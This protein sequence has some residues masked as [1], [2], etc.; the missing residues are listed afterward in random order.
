MFQPFDGYIPG[1]QATQDASR[2]T[3]T[4]G[5]DK[6]NAWIQGNHRINGTYYMAYD[7]DADVTAFGDL[8][9]SLGWWQQSSHPDWVLYKCDQR[10][11]AWVG[12]LPDNVPLD[13]SN[14][15]VVQYQMALVS[16]YM[17]ANGYNSFAADVMS[18][19]N[20]QG[21]CGV[22]TH[23]HTVWVKKFSGQQVDPKWAAATQYWAAYAQWYLH[24]LPLP[25]PFLANAPNWAPP[26]DQ[27]QKELISHLDGFQDEGGFTAFGNH[28]IND[29]GFR[30]KIWWAQYIQ[31]QGKA[32]LVTDLWKGAEPNPVQR[33]FA[34]A[35]YLMGKY[36]QAAMVTAQYG[37]Y[38]VEHYWPEYDSA[39]GSPC[40][41]MYA[42]QGVYFRKNTSSLVIVNTST[43]AV[44]V[45][46]PH[47]ASSYTDIEGR[48]I[49]QPL[50][51]EPDDGW[52]L[53]TQNGCS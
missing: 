15:Q 1:W 21:G 42:T 9:H 29:A 27:A 2:Y 23:N 3:L 7:T 40:A 4:W 43:S 14:P 35:T 18:L 28:L 48:P 33:D 34:I 52:V 10:T 26:G 31:A 11:P 45:T 47:P 51:V 49:H 39:I 8:G 22:W 5:T 50:S 16:P 30:L 24:S 44:D 17:M 41:D 13:I 12:G 25:I 6:P 38:G 53:L 32:F 37:S 20:G 46:L 19:T 36:H